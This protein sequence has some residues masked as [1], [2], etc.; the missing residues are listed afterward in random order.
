MKLNDKVPEFALPDQHGQQRSLSE[1]IGNG[2][3]VLFF[4]PLASSGGC[5]K[6]ACHFRDLQK[7]FEA[8]GA[9][10]VGISTDSVAKQL[11]F[12]TE[13]GFSYPLLSDRQ[14]EVA[15]LFGVRRRLLAKTLPTK[16]ATFI[17]D[18]EGILRFSVA[19]ETN[20]DVH[21]NEALAAL[22]EIS[23]AS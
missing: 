7:E 10:L 18:G 21:A 20:M 15:D 4:Y 13:N 17:V 6:E 2:P 9:S 3:L 8:V 5:T 14:G 1:L 22:A 16:R 11:K 12:A 23:D 19:S